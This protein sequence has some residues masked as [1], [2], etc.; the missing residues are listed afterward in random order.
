MEISSTNSEFVRSLSPVS[1]N[2]NILPTKSNNDNSS[3]TNEKTPLIFIQ[4][5]DWRKATSLVFAD[6]MLNPDNLTAK[7][8]N[9]SNIFV[10]KKIF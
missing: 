5:S 8:V 10:R 9:D 3:L 1:I 6:Q 7:R 2:S 4:T